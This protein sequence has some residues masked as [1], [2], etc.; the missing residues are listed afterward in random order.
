MSD[1][2]GAFWCHVPPS[3][4]Q[5]PRDYRSS[6]WSEHVPFAFWVVNVMRPRQL[7]ELGTWYGMSYLAFCQ[8]IEQ[9]EDAGRA[10]AV[11]TWAGDE[12]T[13]PI[14]RQALA[15]LRS[16]HDPAYSNFSKLLQMTFDQAL[17][18]FEDGSIDLLHIDGLHTYDAVKH[19]FESWLP[20][21]SERAVVLF[22]DT[23]VRDRSFGVHK[24][25]AELCE[26]YP[27]FE[28]E[29]EHGLGVLGVGPEQP[30]ELRALYAATT[31]PADARRVRQ[32]FERFGRS[33]RV[34]QEKLELQQKWEDLKARPAVR[35]ALKLKHAASTVFAGS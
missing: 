18:R 8:A 29:H 11:D 15:S 28:F 23:Q 3:L 2:S 19:D 17:T 1:Q 13:G 31:T 33:V 34:N 26:R 4:L 9:N 25:W 30:A 7:V 16:A 14:A 20:K 6:A 27:G 32:V 24:L 35:A 5:E 10:Y 12:H 22:H 21:L